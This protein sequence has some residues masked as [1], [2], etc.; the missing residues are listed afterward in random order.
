MFEDINSLT[1]SHKSGKAR[2]YSCQKKEQ[3]DEMSRDD[4][5]VCFVLQQLAKAKL[6]FHSASS[7]KQQSMERHVASLHRK[8]KLEQHQPH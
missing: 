4:D 5:K 2:Q 1:R 8:L 6:D 7:L 3:R